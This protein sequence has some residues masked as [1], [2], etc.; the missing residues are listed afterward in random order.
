MNLLWIIL[1][2][3]TLGLIISATCYT[4]LIK[5]CKKYENYQTSL[6][7]NGAEFIDRSI[8]FLNLKAHFTIFGKTFEDKF[9]PQKNIIVL[10]ETTASSFSLTALSIASH[11][12]GHAIQKD[13]NSP[14]LALF[15]GLGFLK[16]VTDFLFVPTVIASIVLLFIPSFI[17]IGIILLYVA[18][19]FW[20]VNFIYKLCSIPLEYNASNLAYKYLK[21]NK[22]LTKK[23]LK[24]AKKIMR[25]AG[26]TYVGGLFANLLK[27]LKGIANSFSRK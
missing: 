20:I 4:S 21:E 26:L 9:D 11:E 3:I 27:I 7:L 13:K 22:L 23:E 25:A 12:L 1:G 18:L 10:S 14:L 2:L 8:G 19:G 5:I 16:I 24:I 6:N 15:I 17:N